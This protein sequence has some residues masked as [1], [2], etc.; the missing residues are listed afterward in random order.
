MAPDYGWLLAILAAFAVLDA[1]VASLVFVAKR[2]ARRRFQRRTEKSRQLNR[3]IGRADGEILGREFAADP[4]GFLLHLRRLQEE[5]SPLP[6][7]REAIAQLL[8]PVD[9]VDLARGG[10]SSSRLDRRIEAYLLLGLSPRGEIG[11]LLV[12]R[13]KEERRRLGR[14]VLLG[15]IARRP[16]AVDVAA[17][18]EAL[19]AGDPRQRA[20]EVASLS[21]LGGRLHAHFSQQ[22]IPP[23]ETGLLLY[24]ASVRSRPAEEDWD[25][26][27][28]LALSRDDEIGTEA[29]RILAERYPA[30]RFLAA[31][32]ER[33][34]RR[35]RLPLARLLGRSLAPGL[36]PELDSWFADPALR[37][38]GIAAASDVLSRNPGSEEVFLRLI[39]G[40]NEAR[41]L[42]L[43]LAIEYRLPA[44]LFH[45]KAP[46]ESGLRAMVARLVEA[47]RAGV[48]LE[49]LELSLPADTKASYFDLVRVLLSG[50]S[51]LSAR[52][53]RQLSPELAAE[54]RLPPPEP[55]ED[56]LNI[57]TGRRD[58]LF[59]AGIVFLGLAIFPLAFVL[60]HFGKLSWLSGQEILY[61]FIFDFQY[62]FTFYTLAVNGSYLFL[63][64]LSMTKLRSQAR[65]WELDLVGLLAQ[66]G[67]L[68]SISIVAP[69]YN[70]EATIVES[71]HSLLS[72]NYPSCQIIVVNDGSKDG[73]L[74]ALLDAFDLVGAP[75]GAESSGLLPTMPVRMVYRSVSL[76][77]LLVVDKANGGK[78]DALNAG[79]NHA[80]GD[81]ICTIDADSVLDPQALSRAMF[82]VA[83]S[84]RDVIAIGGNVFPVNGC[85]VEH[86]HLQ[87][88]SLP[89]E[90]LARFQTVEYLRSFVA[91]RLGWTRLDSLLV[92]SGAFGVFRRRAVM[93][94][95][96]YLTGK[97]IYRHETVGED[98]EIVVRLTRKDREEGRGGKIDYAY[99]ANCWTEVPESWK[100][101]RKQRDRWQR[102]LLEV[103]SFHKGLTF[104]PRYGAAGLLGFPY[105]FIFE[106][107]GPWLESLGYLVL[108]LALLLNL[109][110]PLIPL[111]IFGIAIFFGILI[112]I[113]SI[114]LAERQILYFRPREFFQLLGVAILE[115]FGFRQLMSLGR[116][117]TNI[118][119]FFVNKGW[120]KGQR[121]GFSAPAA[122]PAPVPAPVRGVARVATFTTAPATTRA[123][124]VAGAASPKARPR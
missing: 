109:I 73:T 22:G 38:A 20:E 40:E 43:S 68:P 34:E 102:G 12:A 7:S 60:A 104:R 16:G 14:L 24:L 29:A 80:I 63:L 48:I 99:N 93:E 65:L 108:G 8:A 56:R 21:R 17:L 18:V 44:L 118:Q 49:A 96:G 23:G 89:G 119:F 28:S 66:G 74:R 112:S 83:A 98:M 82:Q 54:L 59:I 111:M 11:P 61:R 27:A 79:L 42:C 103:L 53:A 100:A 10:L 31:F 26:V 106:V 101:L 123:P 41:S 115:N 94:L 71:L 52:L 67:A 84:E 95:G 9:M 69:A 122:A 39:D 81:Y 15:Q 58:K 85:V 117:L 5:A 105:F 116:V 55:E 13:L 1:A 47:G 32:R 51:E 86:G 70:E 2:R 4:R 25:R 35:F 33:P 50:A 6:A 62:L 45:A 92:I 87:E 76:P 72:L 107:V 19:E 97:G 90:P 77:N 78:A 121:K 37:D 124:G 110:D 64:L 113:S 3:A 36:L 114:L 75:S 91:A 57:P 46:L 120:Q 88:I 30:S